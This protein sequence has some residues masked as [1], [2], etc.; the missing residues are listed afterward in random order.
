VRFGALTLG[1]GE[2]KTGQKVIPTSFLEFVESHV[3]YSLYLTYFMLN[4]VGL[5]H[6][7]QLNPTL[8]KRWHVVHEVIA[9]F[10]HVV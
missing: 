10:H 1:E 4:V 8:T 9:T 3:V 2:C 6:A 7:N 5:G